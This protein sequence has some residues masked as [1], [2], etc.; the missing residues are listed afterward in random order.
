MSNKII[1][2][3]VSA[4]GFTFKYR[5]CGMDNTGDL[6]IFLHGFPEKF[7]NVDA[8]DEAM[9]AKNYRCFAFDQ[10]S[11]ARGVQKRWSSMR[12]KVGLRCHRRGNPLPITEIPSGRA[13]IGVPPLAGLWFPCMQIALPAGV[14]CLPPPLEPYRW[15]I[16]NDP[17]R[18]NPANTSTICSSPETRADVL[19]KRSGSS[20]R[21]LA[22]SHR[23]W[24]TITYPF[25]RT[26]KL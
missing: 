2:G 3:Q 15:G 13:T 21:Y 26:R 19:E 9:A 18:R 24:W 10:R 17:T 22:A 11:T 12:L 23:K 1:T 7:R 25:S 4:N 14:R 5:S 16:D 6:V 8:R 20:A